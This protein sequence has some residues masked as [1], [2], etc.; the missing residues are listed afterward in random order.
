M[1]INDL[2]YLSNWDLFK[3]HYFNEIIDS[4]ILNHNEKVY[5]QNDMAF[6]FNIIIQGYVKLCSTIDIVTVSLLY[7]IFR[8]QGFQL[9][10]IAGRLNKVT[11]RVRYTLAI[12][13]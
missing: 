3:K 10:V 8:Y 9:E 12:L 7:R 13:K 2:S 1:F 6:S 4:K 11:K 5:S